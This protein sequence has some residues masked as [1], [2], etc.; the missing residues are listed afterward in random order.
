MIFL[1]LVMSVSKFSSHK[2]T[3]PI[4][5]VPPQV[6]HL[7]LIVSV[8]TFSPSKIAF[9]NTPG[10]QIQIKFQHILLRDIFEPITASLT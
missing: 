8:K 5:L 9:M 3:L 10:I 7:N 4:E 6:L 2:D 1:S